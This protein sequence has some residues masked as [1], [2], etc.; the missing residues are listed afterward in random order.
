MKYLSLFLLLTIV[1]LTRCTAQSGCDPTIN[2][3]PMYGRVTKCKELIEADNRFIKFADQ[4]FPNRKEAS[5]YYTKRGWDY[6]YQ[7]KLDTAMFRFNQA[8]M[9]DSLNA[10]V[11]WG[12]A[13]LMGL[14]HNFKESIP[15]FN[16]AISLNPS[17]IRL[18]MDVSISYGNLF[19]QTK[20]KMY[21]NK[22]I[23]CMQATVKIDPKSAAAYDQ[24]TAAYAYFMQKDSAR[25]YL[26]IADKLDANAV[27][28][29]VRKMLINQ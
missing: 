29:E 10:D 21:L 14:E 26:K 11:Y 19:M 12:F 3:L 24:L 2:R 18:R 15:L 20:D 8:W 23:D 9:L 6:V 25:K 1:F 13:D 17:N 28:P 7:H 5:K 4:N 22:I 27:N 16:R